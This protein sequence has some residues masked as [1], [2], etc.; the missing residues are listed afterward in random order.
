MVKRKRRKGQ[1]RKKNGCD[2]GWRL[3]QSPDVLFTVDKTRRILRMNREMSGVSPEQILGKDSVRLFP[4]RIK[5]WFRKKLKQVFVKPG[6]VHFQY[7]TENS[8]WWEVR[9]VPVRHEGKITEAVVICSDVTERRIRHAQAIR[10]A[11]LATIGVLSAG[12]AHEINNPNGANLFNASQLIRSWRDLAPIL[13]NYWQEYG[14][15]SLGGVP[16]SEARD[17]WPTLLQEILGNTDRIKNIV[18]SMKRLSVQDDEKLDEL[19]DINAT[20]RASMMILNY[21]VKKH[22]DHCHVSFGKSLPRVLGNERQLEQVFIN[23]VLN[24]LQSLP[25]RSRAVQ[26]ATLFDQ[27]NGWIELVVEDEG[28]GILPENLSRLTEP[29]FTTKL[30]A[31]GTGLGLSISNLI[32]LKHGGRIR[33]EPRETVG[34]RVFVAFPAHQPGE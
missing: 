5:S 16:Y 8:V 28:C 21:K 29:F 3:E 20:L 7:S 2:P 1:A 18:N 22:T 13:E 10:H 15:F 33:F 34:T 31:K 6:V 24:A 30:K 12:V 23:V 11:R 4:P 17:A 9:I 27:Q 19:V 25:D 14:D 32:I 26:I